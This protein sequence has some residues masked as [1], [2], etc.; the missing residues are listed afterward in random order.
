MSK[1]KKKLKCIHRHFTFLS[2]DDIECA[3][4]G[5]SIL[6]HVPEDEDAEAY[7]EILHKKVEGS[8]TAFH[9]SYREQMKLSLNLDRTIH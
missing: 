8:Y 4:C 1:S 3:H 6:M 9:R 5:D 7:F 2:K